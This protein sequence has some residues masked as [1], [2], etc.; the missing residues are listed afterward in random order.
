LTFV[1][2]C[3]NKKV[4]VIRPTGSTLIVHRYYFLVRFCLG[5]LVLFRSIF[6]AMCTLQ[7]HQLE[8]IL[9]YFHANPI[10]A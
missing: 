4:C 8:A 5:T 6:T 7:D 9:P 2:Y 10:Q 1:P 3:T